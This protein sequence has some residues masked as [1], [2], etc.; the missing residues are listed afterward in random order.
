MAKHV[1]I[2]DGL[3][4]SDLTL[5]DGLVLE[6]DNDYQT[7]EDEDF[8]YSTDVL[9]SNEEALNL[10]NMD[11]FQDDNDDDYNN[12][13]AT[14]CAISFAALKTKMTDVSVDGKV[15]KLIKQ[16]GV[17]DVVPYNAQVTINY[18]GHLE[19]RDEPFDSSFVRGG[20]EIFFLNCGMLISGIEI[21]IR[22]MRKHE[23]AVFIIHPDLAYGKYGCAP[24]IPPNEET[25]FIIHLVDYMDN[26]I[27]AFENL[28]LEEKKK[29][30]NVI[31]KV[32]AKFN[33]A[34]DYFNKQ[35]IRQAIRDYS[36]GLQW[37]EE[38]ELQN[39]EEEN[40][41]NNLLSKGYNNLAVCFNKEN[42]VRR[43]CSACNR[44][45]IPTAKTH[46]N[47]GRALWKMGEYSKAM[48]KLQLARKLEPR[49][50][51]IIKEIRIVNEKQR[52]YLEVEKKLWR[53]CIKFGENKKPNT[54][55][56]EEV[57]RNMCETFSK[58]DQV[59]RLPLPDSLT[60]EEDKCIRAQAAAFGLMVTTHQ[61]YGREITYINKSTY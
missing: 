27:E 48:E 19:Y 40:E 25:L 61:R 20:A 52:H 54:S 4:I 55:D 22:T 16:Q 31:K 50:E 7:M 30:E 24:R 34:K 38:A 46:F 39:E 15:M 43:A 33:I 56:F 6:I 5:Q 11:D 28:S 49:N 37:L 21:A 18:V 8:A 41:A 36:K 32:K 1:N 42:M 35:K 45:P 59:L 17:G 2:Y 9:L 10:L 47:F 13:P 26:S 12:G 51:E 29:F 14:I 53:G 60:P 58:D 44:V 57:V 23:I 3:S